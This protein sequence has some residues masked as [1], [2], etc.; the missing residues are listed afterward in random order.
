MKY[1][2]INSLI[3]AD[4]TYRRGKLAVIDVKKGTF[5][6]EMLS[7]LVPAL[8]KNVDTRDMLKHEP[9]KQR[10]SFYQPARQMWMDFYWERCQIPYRFTAA[11][12]QSIVKIGNFL[13]N[14][15]DKAGALELW[16]QMLGSWDRLE[17]FYRNNL[18]LKF[19]NGQLNKIINQLKNGKQT[20]KSPDRDNAD[21]IRRQFANRNR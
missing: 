5:D 19:I 20:A 14:L 2:L 9:K 15:D 16:K 17:P 10:S 11:D 18:D 21:D 4:I 12:G 1:T 3:T 7:M 8:E 13:D 6:L